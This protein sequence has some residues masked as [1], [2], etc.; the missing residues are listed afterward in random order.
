MSVFGPQTKKFYQP[1][2]G[3]FYVK[4]FDVDLDNLCVG[5][6]DSK[7]EGL[8]WLAE[9]QPREASSYVYRWYWRTHITEIESAAGLC[10]FKFWNIN[11]HVC[12]T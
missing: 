9:A 12:L 2:H 3:Q 4:I 7:S 1:R 11:K 8:I 10:S 6:Y 5:R